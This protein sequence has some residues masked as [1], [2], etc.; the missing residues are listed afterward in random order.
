M[1]FTIVFVQKGGTDTPA[2]TFLIRKI[3]FNKEMEKEKQNLIIFVCIAYLFCGLIW[4]AP[5]EA[6]K[7]TIRF[8]GTKMS[9]N[10]DEVFLKDVFKSISAQKDFR[11]K[12]DPALLNQKI[13]ISFENLSFQ[14]GLKRILGQINHILLFD[15]NQEPSGV[16]IV[17][18]GGS[19]NPKGMRSLDTNFNGN[20]TES[21]ESNDVIEPGDEI[22][23]PPGL[24]LSEAERAGVETPEGPVGAIPGGPIEITP[25][26]AEM[27]R[28][29]EELPPPGGDVIES[30]E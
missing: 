26:E 24:P 4:I 5:V 13:S 14:D 8:D 17:S 20:T 12:G 16:F 7:E 28:V 19:Q 2:L 15:K 23:E 6:K 27:F 29:V 25:E 3:I 9:A 18:S 11:V 30:S 21:R 1:N 22:N 10:I